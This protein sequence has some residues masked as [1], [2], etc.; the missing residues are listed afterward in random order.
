MSNKRN[1][2]MSY[3][4]KTIEDAISY[5]KPMAVTLTAIYTDNY[6]YP[7]CPRCKCPMDREYLSFCDRCGQRLKWYGYKKHTEFYHI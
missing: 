1:Y 3:R 4:R 5:R 2:Q 7:V 6:T